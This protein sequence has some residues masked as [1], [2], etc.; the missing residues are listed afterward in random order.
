MIT[1]S[2][3]CHA[4]FKQF[5]TSYENFLKSQATKVYSGSVTNETQ[6]SCLHKKHKQ[7]KAYLTVGITFYFEGSM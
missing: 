2:C 1:F 4:V 7:L 5:K 3:F 6:K